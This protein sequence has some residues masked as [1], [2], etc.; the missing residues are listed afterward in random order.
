MDSKAQTEKEL[1]DVSTAP[2]GS[3]DTEQN[4]DDICSEVADA[5]KECTVEVAH[6][7][8]QDCKGSVQDIAE[9]AH[10]V[11]TSE[12]DESKTGDDH[13]STSMRPQEELYSVAKD[14]SST[15]TCHE[16]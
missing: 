15:T 6:N 10:G 9:G 12:K 13:V 11:T 14:N 7:V 4:S 8:L 3:G 2:C 16:G 1:G 5:K